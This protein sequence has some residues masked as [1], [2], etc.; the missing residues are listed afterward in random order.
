MLKFF[1]L[2][3]FIRSSFFSVVNNLLGYVVFLFL[4]SLGIAPKNAVTIWYIPAIIC[5]FWSNYRWVF[6]AKLN[7][8]ETIIR[9][10]IVYVSAYLV[11]LLL[12]WGFVDKLDYPYQ[13]VQLFAIAPV[14]VFLFCGC[15][16]FVF[17]GTLG[18]EP[19]KG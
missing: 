4:T 9:F 15:K 6:S 5:S 19:G 3:Q 18:L 7:L 8:P 17:E 16:Y 10:I 14:A 11:N 12:L 13:F 2:L 1:I